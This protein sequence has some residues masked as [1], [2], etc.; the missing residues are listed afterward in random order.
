MENP[1]TSALV[2]DHQNTNVIGLQNIT[3]VTS[4]RLLVS[5]RG[6]G[7]KI[8]L[9]AG[10]MFTVGNHGGDY[11]NAQANAAWYTVSNPPS[12]LTSIA[13]TGGGSGTGNFCS[14]WGIEVNGSRVVDLFAS[15]C[16]SLL[17][18]P[19]NYEA[20]SGN[21]G[22]NYATLNPLNTGNN[23]TLSDGN[24]RAT[25]NSGGDYGS[26]MSTIGVSSGKWYC[27][28]TL[29]N[30]RFGFGVGTGETDTSTWLG[31]TST[32][33][34]WRKDGN[35]NAGR[36]NGSNITSVSYTHLTLPTT[37]IV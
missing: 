27:E 23:L 29:I 3:G 31:Q 18:S 9:S 13:A 24:L 32:D 15:N 33:W 26:S 6:G 11:S 36:H 30:D 4:L 37:V 5:S 14:V 22:G 7:A 12:T 34:V 16:D 35:G 2:W 8:G 19:T 1:Q 17:D 21:N 25:Q 10:A 20:D 28:M